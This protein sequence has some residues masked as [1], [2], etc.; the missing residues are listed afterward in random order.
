MRAM[1]YPMHHIYDGGKLLGGVADE[2]TLEFPPLRANW[3]HSVQI[4]L[5]ATSQVMFYISMVQRSISI[6]EYRQFTVGCILPTTCV[7]V[8]C[9]V[10]VGP[11]SRFSKLKSHCSS[12]SNNQSMKPRFDQSPLGSDG[13]KQGYTTWQYNCTT[14]RSTVVIG[15][16]RSDSAHRYTTKYLYLYFLRESTKSAPIKARPR[17]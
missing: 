5:L 17:D 13:R 4:R 8:W 2:A 9:L 7:C 11:C 10:P 16:I 6:L 15:L 14:T 1:V 12:L 3:R